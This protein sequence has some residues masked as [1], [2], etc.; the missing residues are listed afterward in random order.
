MK[1]TTN[2]QL[3]QW[4]KTDRIM[5]DDFNADNAKL[6][7]A[8]AAHAAALAGCGNC[9]IEYGAYTGDGNT[10][11][12]TLTF[13]GKPLLVMIQQADRGN[14][15]FLMQGCAY[16]FSIIDPSNGKMGKYPVRL[17]TKWNGNSVTW[18]RGDGGN[19]VFDALNGGGK[20]HYIAL[21]AAE[22]TESN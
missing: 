11:G 2:Y 14:T 7:A 4:A 18:S 22:P 20:Y 16:G 5:M 9:K 19:T 12:Y 15:G 3:N 8:L 1:K 13:P 6:E 21:L 17:L 10:D